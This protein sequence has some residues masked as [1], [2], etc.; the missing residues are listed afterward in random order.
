MLCAPSWNSILPE[1]YMDRFRKPCPRNPVQW[2]KEKVGFCIITK[3]IERLKG[4]KK[5]VSNLLSIAVKT[6]VVQKFPCDFTSLS[7]PHSQLLS[8][9][10][11]HSR[12]SFYVLLYFT[13]FCIS[14]R[15]WIETPS[16]Q[17]LSTLLRSSIVRIKMWQSKFPKWNRKP[18]RKCEWNHLGGSRFNPTY[19]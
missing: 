3:T 6:R 18:T 14:H 17:V 9:P 19:R 8:Q 16:T 11:P 1:I 15:H 4:E 12:E 13:I 7:D 10:R 2:T 5:R